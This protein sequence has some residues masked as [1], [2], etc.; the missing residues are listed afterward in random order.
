MK[1]ITFRHAARTLTLTGGLVL[2]GVA[3]APAAHADVTNPADNPYPIT[4]T[5]DDG[6][7]YTDGQDTLPGYDD[8]A[9]TYIPGAWFDFANNRV[10]YPDG[11][12]IPWTEWDRASGYKDWKAK[13]AAA[14][15]APAPAAPAP[16]P[17]TSTSTGSSKPSGTSGTSTASGSDPVYAADASASPSASAEPSASTSPRPSASQLAAHPSAEPSADAVVAA[18]GGDAAGGSTSSAGL[19][20]LAVLF[21]LG[22]AAFGASTLFR[23]GGRRPA[24]LAS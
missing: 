2:A 24:S 18:S 1:R 12:S 7:T 13:Q 22:G 14:A 8:T 19:A 17:A 4:V 9:C 11:Q 21:G 16:A 6:L 20:I 3:L 23:K 10:R 5:G 15:P